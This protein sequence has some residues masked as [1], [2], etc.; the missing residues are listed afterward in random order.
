VNRQNRQDRQTPEEILVEPSEQADRRA[1]EVIGAAIEVHTHLGPG[2]LESVYEE[3]LCVEL[4]D[5]AI[6]FQRQVRLGV[7][8]KG[9]V[10]GEARLDLLVDTCLLI[11]LKA[12]EAIAPIHRAQVIS[13]LRATKLSLALLFNFNVR[14]LPN[15]MHRIVRS[16]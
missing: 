9:R 11:E 6:P 10:V 16:H 1:S 12:V 4:T 13:Y 5:R 15:G 7:P 8:Y 2:F 3:A 14:L